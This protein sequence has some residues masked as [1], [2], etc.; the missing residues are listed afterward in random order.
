MVLATNKC[1]TNHWVDGND[2]KYKLDENITNTRLSS[3]V[4]WRK[5]RR[6]SKRGRADGPLL[7]MSSC[8]LIQDG[9]RYVAAEHAISMPIW[10]I[11]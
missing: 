7:R 10:I 4:V 6:V 8:V 2:L 11:N 1:K 3:V 9:D 5:D